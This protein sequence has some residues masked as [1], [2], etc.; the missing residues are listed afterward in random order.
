VSP[1][2]SAPQRDPG[3]R[4]HRQKATPQPRASERDPRPPVRRPSENVA[5]G[6]AGAGTTAPPTFWCA[7]FA[8]CTALAALE[9]RR[10]GAQLLVPEAPGAFSLRDR[11][12]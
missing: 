8:A 2:P 7:V 3:G 4:A 12:G 6:A 9:L 10:F 11:P 5:A 1:K